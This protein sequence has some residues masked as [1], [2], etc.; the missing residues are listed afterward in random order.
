MDPHAKATVDKSPDVRRF[1]PANLSK[2]GA[3][4]FSLH[5]KQSLRVHSGAGPLP[6][7]DTGVVSFISIYENNRSL[8]VIG[9][10][11]HL[12][13]EVSEA[14]VSSILLLLLKPSPPNTGKVGSRTHEPKQFD[15]VFQEVSDQILAQSCVIPN[16]W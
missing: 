12:L 5:T 3:D 9:K 16:P 4:V 6:G 15:A 7:L 10:S 14:F 13:E 8:S 1:R 2:V 11:Y